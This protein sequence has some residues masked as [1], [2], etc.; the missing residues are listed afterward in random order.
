[1]DDSLTIDN[2]TIPYSK[3]D[4]ISISCSGGADSSLL[5]YI[6]MK[7]KQA[8]TI[9][10][11]TVSNNFKGRLS[12]Q[13][14][15]RVIE[16]CIQL[17]GYYNIIHHVSYVDVQD[18]K[19]MF[20]NLALQ[21]EITKSSIVYTAGTANPPKEIADSFCG[22]NKNSEHTQRDP[23][24]QRPIIGSHGIFCAPFT[25]IDKQRVKTLYDHFDL[26]ESLFPHTKSCEGLVKET[27]NFTKNCEECWW[28]LE[29]KWAF[30]KF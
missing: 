3:H 9:H 10:V 4:T 23:T 29:R 19:L 17:T 24:V 1:M 28:C 30:G 16:Q 7:Y 14:S 21:K 13:S 22:E 18:S 8:G 15:M 20:D 26:T 5:L 12:A 2:I 27:D 11:H 25:N 6:L